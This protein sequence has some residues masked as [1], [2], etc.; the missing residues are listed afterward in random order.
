MAV[1][2]EIVKCNTPLPILEDQ[3][4][5]RSLTFNCLPQV[6]GATLTP[7]FQSLSY[8]L[9]KNVEKLCCAQSP[10]SASLTKYNRPLDLNS[11]QCSQSVT[12][13]SFHGT[14]DSIAKC[15]CPES[16]ILIFSSVL[17]KHFG[18][19]SPA[20]PLYLHCLQSRLWLT[21]FRQGQ[22]ADSLM[23]NN[24]LEEY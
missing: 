7:I 14:S 17:R 23:T 20:P 24:L 12:S 18:R 5:K 3:N 19:S 13:F 1:L 2:W 21:F 11:T 9:H 8:L 6:T 10:K 15:T 22:G 16:A 4:W